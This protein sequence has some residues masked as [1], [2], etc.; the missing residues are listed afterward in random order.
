MR[1]THLEVIAEEPSLEAFLRVVLPK[2]LVPETSFE[3]YPHQGKD[4]LRKKLP[5]RLRGYA[6]WLPETS[7]IV[8]V[9]DRDDDDCAEL[10]AWMDRM[11]TEA[12]LRS[13]S[14]AGR[15]PWQVANRIAIEELEAW[16]FGDWDA[17]R[18]SYPR[19]NAAIRR[20]AQFRDPD[21]IAGG[22]WETLERILQ[23]AGYF[24]NGLRKIE[25][26]RAIGAR[27]DP[28]RSQSRSFQVFRDVVFDAFA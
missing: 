28:Q 27:F 24:K 12:N 13:R 7:R 16:Y 23:K 22:T 2:L 19:V 26:A 17:V 3:I 9:V 15:R 14:N 8:V 18:E 4:D 5:S 20:K 11:A 1:A 10:K 6:S 25:V 21:A